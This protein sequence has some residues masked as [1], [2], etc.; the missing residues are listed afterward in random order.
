M[1]K[2]NISN[3]GLPPRKVSSFL[4]P[5]KDNLGLMILG[6]HS[7]P[8]ECGQVHFRQNGQSTKN[9]IREHHQHTRLGQADKSEV[10]EHRFNHDHL[11][12]SQDTKIIS[13]KSGYMD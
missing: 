8:C 7:N 6:V 2:H 9:R 10:A 4:C 5:V 11:I 12:K 1:A 13:T 3:V